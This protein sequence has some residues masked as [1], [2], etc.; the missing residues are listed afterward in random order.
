MRGIVSEFL[1]SQLDSSVI[2]IPTVKSDLGSR[3]GHRLTRNLLL[4]AKYH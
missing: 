3:M 4:E 1:L 2:N